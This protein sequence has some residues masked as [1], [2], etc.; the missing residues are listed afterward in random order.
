MLKQRFYFIQNHIKP[1]KTIICCTYVV[2]KN[3]YYYLTKRVIN[4]SVNVVLRKKAN[5][6]GQYPIAILITKYR[7]FSFISTGQYISEKFWDQTHQNVKNHTQ[8]LEG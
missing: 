6:Q 4:A 3:D 8:I 5:K 2:P 1:R 7:K